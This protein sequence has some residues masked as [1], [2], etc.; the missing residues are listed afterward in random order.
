MIYIHDKLYIILQ[1]VMRYGMLY[2]TY[3][4]NDIIC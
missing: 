2:M 3:I 4:Y 1:G